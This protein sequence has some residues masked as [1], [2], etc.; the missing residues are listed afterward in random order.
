MCICSPVEITRV[1]TLNERTGKQKQVNETKIW[2]FHFQLCSS[3]G[4]GTVWI[5]FAAGLDTCDPCDLKPYPRCYFGTDSTQLAAYTD[6]RFTCFRELLAGTAASGKVDLLLRLGQFVLQPFLPPVQELP[7]HPVG[8]PAR[9]EAGGE[10]DRHGDLQRPLRDFCHV[11]LCSLTGAAGQPL[12][13]T[14][15]N[16]SPSTALTQEVVRHFRSRDITAEISLFST[17][18]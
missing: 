6:S 9:Q 18:V 15:S 13:A 5:C 1:W 3:L 14:S 11:H 7:P 8:L 4:W 17:D 12:A 2:T 10:G 16:H